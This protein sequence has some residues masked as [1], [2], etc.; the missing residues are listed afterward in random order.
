MTKK[1]IIIVAG[2]LILCIAMGFLYCNFIHSDIKLKNLQKELLLII[3][4]NFL[5]L[6]T[7]TFR[8]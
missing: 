5:M 6:H 4:I 2:A 8:I 3:L 1:N 7:G